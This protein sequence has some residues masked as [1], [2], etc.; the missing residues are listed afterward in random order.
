V[1]VTANMDAVSLSSDK[2]RGASVQELEVFDPHLNSEISRFPY[3]VDAPSAKYTDVAWHTGV[4][5]FWGR[6]SSA[7]TKQELM[8]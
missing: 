1:G 8:H 4:L 5:I 7:V 2:P 6:C 3:Q